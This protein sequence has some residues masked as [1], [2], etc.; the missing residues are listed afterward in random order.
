MCGTDK[1]TG[2]WSCVKQTKITLVNIQPC[3]RITCI[4]YGPTHT[5]VM[6][7]VNLL[8]TRGV[9]LRHSTRGCGHP[10]TMTHMC[11]AFSAGNDTTKLPD[12]TSRV[13]FL[14]HTARLFR[15]SRLLYHIRRLPITWAKCEIPSAADENGGI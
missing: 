11:A 7:L 4:V 15:L 9:A 10:Q 3:P 2:H 6:V 12:W 13:Y 8:V 14:L 5:S 1:K